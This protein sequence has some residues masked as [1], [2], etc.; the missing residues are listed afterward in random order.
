MPPRSHSNPSSHEPRAYRGRASRHLDCR[1][2]ATCRKHRA[3][4]SGGCTPSILRLGR[5]ASSDGTASRQRSEDLTSSGDCRGVCKRDW[6]YVHRQ[7]AS[8]LHRAPQLTIGQ[9]NLT[10]RQSAAAIGAPVRHSMVVKQEILAAGDR[11]NS[12]GLFEASDDIRRDV[13]CPGPMV[14]TVTHGS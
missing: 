7:R 11:S 3:T 4:S 1:A 5:P 12:A 8:V 13:V 2:S 10:G 9:Q 14:K 6:H